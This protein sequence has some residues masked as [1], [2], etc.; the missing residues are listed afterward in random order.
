MREARV[1]KPDSDRFIR[2]GSLA[3]VA[4]KGRMVVKGRRCPVLVVHDQGRVFAL[5][6]RCPH[7]GFALHKGII[8]DGILTCPWHHARFDLAS[9]GTFDLWADDV[10]TA[11]VQV[12]DGQCTSP[13]NAPCAL[14][15]P[16]TGADASAWRTIW[17]W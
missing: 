14:S 17:G 13:R 3:E 10:P 9:G 1:M 2:V 8:R 12:E 15:R 11:A 16:R 6:D 5:D 4:A 7:L